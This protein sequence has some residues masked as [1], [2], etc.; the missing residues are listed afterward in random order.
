MRH[1]TIVSFQEVKPIL[2]AVLDVF[3]LLSYDHL[4]LRLLPQGFLIKSLLMN[5]HVRNPLVCGVGLPLCF[6]IPS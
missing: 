4:E 3:L 2:T 6:T 5:K 1:Y